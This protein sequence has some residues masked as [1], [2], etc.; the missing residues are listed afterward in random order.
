MKTTL[1]LILVSGLACTTFAWMAQPD[2]TAAQ[3][4][5]T[6]HPAPTQHAAQ[7]PEQPPVPPAPKPIPVPDLPIIKKTELEGGI[8]AEDMKI[9]EGYEVK[10]GGA[11]VAL[12]HGTL[13]EGGT[14]FDSAYERGEPI[15]FPLSGVIQGWQKGVPG[16]K[17]GGIRKLTIPSALAYGPVGSPPKVPANADLVFVIEI[18]DALQM[19]DSKLGDGEEVTGTCVPVTGMVIKD[20]DGKEI[21]KAPATRPYIW[22]PGEMNPPGTMYDSIQLGVMGMKVGGKRTIKIPKQMN[23]SPPQLGL[24]RPTNVALEIELELVAVRNLPRR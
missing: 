14:M 7:P 5:S 11:V 18:V 20:K 10:E 4:A 1:A 24:T 17:I 12:Y 6:S 15:A 16:M 2:K 13:K 19:I 21:E 9:G 8:I 23:G 22:I 3:P